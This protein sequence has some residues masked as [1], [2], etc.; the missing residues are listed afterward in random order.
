[1]RILATTF[2][3]VLLGVGGRGVPAA[4][5]APAAA[6]PADPRA[7]ALQ[8]LTDEYPREYRRAANRVV[9]EYAP[10]ALALV[11][12]KPGDDLGFDILLRLVAEA[13]LEDGGPKCMP[14]VFRLLADHYATGKRTEE[15]LLG[16]P[17]LGRFPSAKVWFEKVVADHPS[18]TA[19]AVA[20]L[21]LAQVEAAAY[22]AEVGPGRALDARKN[23]AKLF[24]KVGDE[25]GDVKLPGDGRPRPGTV[26]DRAETLFAES[27]QLAVGYPFPDVTGQ[28]L[29]GDPDP[30]TKYRGKV[31]VLDVWATWCAPCKKMIPH[32]RELVARHANDPFAFV[33][34]AAD[35][36]KEAVEEFLK[37]TPMPWVHWWGAAGGKALLTKLNVSVLPTVYVLDHNGVIRA[38]NVRGAKLDVAVDECLA[39]LKAAP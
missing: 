19:K 5:P 7:E 9:D 22:A 15:L 23:A 4:A 34:I 25:Y 28:T 16:A 30:L 26:A 18:R 27:Y 21:Y 20:A 24:G 38:K 29:A 12:E 32:E 10:R 13:K 6:K 8:R 36:E 17:D 11:A 31:V 14:Q 3:V 2:T 39:A 33:S 35:N 37:D 1:M